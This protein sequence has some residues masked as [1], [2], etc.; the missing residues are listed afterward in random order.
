MEYI[1]LTG[2]WLLKTFGVAVTDRRVCRYLL[3]ELLLRMDGVA[4]TDC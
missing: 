1:L 4:V 2:V 3:E